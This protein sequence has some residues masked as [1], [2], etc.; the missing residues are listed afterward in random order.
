[1]SSAPVVADVTN[2]PVSVTPS[3][4]PSA[5][6]ESTPPAPTN[7]ATVGKPDFRN[8]V[9]EDLKDIGRLL[10]LFI[11]AIAMG[12]V[13]TSERDRLRFV[14]A[15]EH[16]RAI[17]T[18]NPCGLF[19]RL[20]RNGLWSFLT[21]DDEDTANERLKRHLYGKP[22]ERKASSP[23]EVREAVELSEDA[24][25]VQAIRA[26]VT[27]TKYQG[28]GF[29]LLRRERPEWTRERWDCALAELEQAF[30]CRQR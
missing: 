4:R 25:L 27:R 30:R 8:V 2:G 3:I 14:A 15:A 28:D 18:K 23:F 16:A 11:Q 24:C 26:A 1:M 20:V 13:T 5:R 22:P 12:L 29:P 21:Q 17:G 10:G 19:V 7:P 6:P 9:I